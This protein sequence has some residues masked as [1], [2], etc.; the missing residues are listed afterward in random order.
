MTLGEIYQQGKGVLFKAGN[1]SPAFDSVCLFQKVFGLD[2]QA[3][4]IHSNESADAAKTKEYLE[5]IYERAG[6]RPLQ[7]ILGKW[8]F[9]QLELYVGEGVLIPR[10]ETE[11]LVY[12]AA[13]LLKS[14]NSPKI[15]DLCSGTGAVA[16]GLASLLPQARITGAEL[17]DKAFYYLN[18]NIEETGVQNVT[19]VQMDILNPQS[20]ETL[21]ALDCIVSNPPYVTTGELPTLQTEVQNEPQSAL[22]GGADGL[23]F[24]RAIAALW[25]P[26]LR[27]GGVAA[28][29]VGD[30]QAAEVAKLFEAA[31]LAKI[32]IIEDFNCI[33]RVVCGIWQK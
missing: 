2:R 10:E 1:Q 7:Y 11:L 32:D 6:G 5:L 18:R 12:T 15:L 25:L 31:G 33:E 16:L 29:E 3:L 9:M 21:S 19:P 23:V 28:V 30:G 14:V 4:L 24:Y 20:A 13:E 8:P 17:Y 26:K 27:R 22:D